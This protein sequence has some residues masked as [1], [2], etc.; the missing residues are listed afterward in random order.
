MNKN[1]E[2]N[3]ASVTASTWFAE[4]LQRKVLD[5]REAT[6]LADAIGI[7]R[8]SIYAYAYLHRSPKLDIVA[9]VM[10]YYG[11]N[12]IR[13]PLITLEDLES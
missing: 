12:F 4:Y 9:K 7:E 13:I 8:K 6:K 10:A 11:E 1:V 2:P 3:Y 5:H